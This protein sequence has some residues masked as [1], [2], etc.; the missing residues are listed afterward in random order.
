[1]GELIESLGL[2]FSWTWS[3]FW[4]LIPRK[5]LAKKAQAEFFHSWYNLMR[6]LM[7][8]NIGENE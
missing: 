8:G 5:V 3:S 6:A 4:V 1:M 7:N 2:F